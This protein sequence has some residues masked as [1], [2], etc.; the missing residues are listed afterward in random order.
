MNKADGGV[1]A[2]VF[3]GDVSDYGISGVTAKC[4]FP[5]VVINIDSGDSPQSCVCVTRSVKELPELCKQCLSL[6]GPQSRDWEEATGTPRRAWQ[7]TRRGRGWGPFLAVPYPP[8]GPG[9]RR[10]ASQNR[11]S[12]SYKV[13]GLG[14]MPSECLLH[15][16]FLG[17]TPTG[18]TDQ[19]NLCC[20]NC[21]QVSS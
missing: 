8:A 12:V 16:I 9:G 4:C 1:S 5:S 10:W 20:R 3:V 21:L 11:R 13:K 19:T 6:H 18:E 2:W 15:V 7:E 17:E 14:A